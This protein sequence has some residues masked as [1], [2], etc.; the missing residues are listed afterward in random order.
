M[1]IEVTQHC[2]PD[3]RR[4]QLLM[5]I[6]DEYLAQICLIQSC[7]C[8]LATEELRTGGG[9]HYIT[10]DD[11]DFAIEN[12]PADGSVS[13]KTALLKMI[14]AFD[15]NV[16]ETWKSFFHEDAKPTGLTDEEAKAVTVELPDNIIRLGPTGKFPDG[17]MYSDDQGELTFA[18]GIDEE[19]KLII[20]K[21][22]TSVTHLGM[23][24]EQ[25][26]ALADNLMSKAQELTG[27]G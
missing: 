24:A 27:G 16:F 5:D 14:K 9:A 19:K 20:I 8:W 11:G 6:P 3:G 2:R 1:Q 26:F 18:I 15:K 7:G 21:F 10:C 23:T 25:A 17:K 4:K 22:G 13:I 12:T